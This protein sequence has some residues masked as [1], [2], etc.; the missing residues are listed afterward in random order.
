[1][2]HR[3]LILPVSPFGSGGYNIA[4]AHDLER[5]GG[6]QPDDHVVIYPHPGQPLPDGA[7]TIPRPGKL[8]VGR[9]R[10]LIRRRTTTEV[11]QGQLRRAIGDRSYNSIFCGEV[12]FYRALRE[13]FPSQK[14]QVR[15]HNLFSLPATRQQF[16]AYSLDPVFRLNLAL[17][18]RL[19]REILRDPLVDPILIAKAERDYARLIYPTRDFEVWSPPIAIQQ[20]RP[21]PKTPRLAYLGSLASHQRDGMRYFVEKVLPEIRAINPAVEFHMYGNGSTAWSRPDAG[22]YGHGFYEGDGVPFD[23]DALFICPDLL[24]G[25]IKIKIG[26]W[27]SWGVP[28]IAT[29]YAMDGYAIGELDNVLVED[30]GDWSRA[31]VE[32]FK[33]G[34]PS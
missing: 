16:R 29:P 23:G 3:L 10:N 26:E 21:R 12:T 31:I 24:G 14:M 2:N 13:I 1:M 28:F 7:T 33:V 17:F 27:L 6:I 30:I 34:P 22:V 20:S 8:S 19:E 32:Y 11:S 25:G 9:I 5:L 4:V 18:T 15:F